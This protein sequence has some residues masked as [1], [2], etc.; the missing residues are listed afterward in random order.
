MASD[1][2]LIKEKGRLA[3]A[4]PISEECLSKIK[5]GST[6]AAAIRRQRNPA[7]HR[8]LWALLNAVWENQQT[9]ATTQDLL[10]A[11]KIAT[12]LFDTGKTVDGIP[13]IQ[14]HS[15]SFAAMDQTRFEQWYDK[16]IDVV[17]TKILPNV[18][19]EDLEMRVHEIITGSR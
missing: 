4:D 13:F 2:L 7:H 19:R 12:G 15:I 5:E 3:A 6:V 18:C 16:A 17:L 10:Q 9:F 8:K 1:V 11:I 14:P